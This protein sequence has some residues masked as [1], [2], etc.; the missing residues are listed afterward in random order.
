M[1]DRVDRVLHNIVNKVTNR[2]EPYKSAT[3]E[4]KPRKVSQTYD[5]KNYKGMTWNKERNA[6]DYNLD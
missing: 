2:K 3:P 6:Y 5:P 1:S 4:P